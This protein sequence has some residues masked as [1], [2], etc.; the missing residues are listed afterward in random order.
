MLS[1]VCETAEQTLGLDHW[2]PAVFRANHGN[3]LVSMGRFER[4]EATLLRSLDVVEAALDADH[5]H[6]IL[7][8]REATTPLREMA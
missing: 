1:D 4:A 2:I 6:A 5:G 3:T 7:S 8:A